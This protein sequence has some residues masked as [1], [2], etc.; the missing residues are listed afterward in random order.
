MSVALEDLMKRSAKQA[1][2]QRHDSFAIREPVSGFEHL[3]DIV[4]RPE[5]AV[6]NFAREVIEG[7][8][9]E[10]PKAAWEGFTG[11]RR[12]TFFDIA[13]DELGF[14]TEPILNVP[15]WKYVPNIIEGII[16]AGSSPA[17]IMGFGL[18]VFLD[19]LSWVGVGE[20]TKLGEFSRLL[21]GGLKAEEL[22]KGSKLARYYEDFVARTGRA[23]TPLA[24]TVADQARQGQR[25]L[26]QIS[27]PWGKPL[28]P[29]VVGQPAWVAA[30]QLARL[31]RQTPQL[32]GIARLFS[33]FGIPGDVL[34]RWA[35]ARAKQRY[36][37]ETIQLRLLELGQQLT[38]EDAKM[39]RRALE[40]ER[41]T[42]TVVREM[43]RHAPISES[44]LATATIVRQLM[45]QQ[46]L[47]PLQEAFV[48]QFKREIGIK[49]DEDLVEILDIGAETI[50]D[51][52][53]LPE[54]FVFPK[55]GEKTLKELLEQERFGGI[56]I[57]MP[58]GFNP[59]A[60]GRSG[61]KR[62]TVTRSPGKPLTTGEVN[63]LPLIQGQPWRA[64]F[65]D[66]ND[67]I[68]GHQTAEDLDILI[69]EL[70]APAMR[71]VDATG[72][73]AEMMAWTEETAR[74]M[75]E[76][77][78]HKNQVERLVDERAKYAA[79]LEEKIE[80]IVNGYM[81][82]PMYELTELIDEF[83]GWLT[84]EHGA[85][86]FGLVTRE[87]KTGRFVKAP[88]GEDYRDLFHRYWDT[89][90]RFEHWINTN[91][92]R[93]GIPKRRHV[94][95]RKQF[96]GQGRYNIDKIAQSMHE[97]GIIAGGF[98]QDLQSAME[99][100]MRSME[101]AMDTNFRAVAIKHLEEDPFEIDSAMLN[102]TANLLARMKEEIPVYGPARKVVEKSAGQ[103]LTH[104]SREVPIKSAEVQYSVAEEI[105]LHR[106]S[107]LPQRLKNVAL[108]L[109]GVFNDVWEMEA[110]R[111]L[112]HTRLPAYF[113]HIRY[114]DLGKISWLARIGKKSPVRDPHNVFAGQ[115]ALAGTIDEINQRMGREF[116]IEDLLTA[117]FIRAQA[118]A[119]MV[120][121]HDF[122]RQVV[123]EHGFSEVMDKNGDLI[124]G[125]VKDVQAAFD[126]TLEHPEWGVYFPKGER[127][128]YEA[129][130][131]PAQI[132]RRA[133]REAVAKAGAEGPAAESWKRARQYAAKK[134]G[135]TNWIDFERQIGETAE[136]IPS[137]VRLK[138]V[139]DEATTAMGLEHRPAS[140]LET[141]QWL[142]SHNPKD[143][144]LVQIKPHELKT[145]VALGKNPEAYLLPKEIADFMNRAGAFNNT[146]EGLVEVANFI[147]KVRGI[148]VPWTLFIFPGYHTRNAIGNVANAL[149]AGLNNPARYADA[150]WLQKH[151]MRPGEEALERLRARRW[152][153]KA[154][155]EE[156]SGEKFISE[157]HQH[158]VVDTGY[159]FTEWDEIGLK[160]IQNEVK[161]KGV[162]RWAAAVSP[163]PGSNEFLY[164]GYK[165]GGWIE[166]NAKIALY[167]DRRL[168]GDTAELAARAVRK[169]LF[170]YDEITP[171]DR[172]LK[173]YFFPFSVWFKKN[174][175]LQ[176]MELVQ[177]PRTF[178]NLR[179]AQQL[180]EAAHDDPDSEILPTWMRESFPV[181]I[182]KG[183]Q[184]KSRYEYFVLRNW[185]PAVELQ[186][187]FQPG[188]TTLEMLAPWFQLPLA[189]KLNYN[190]YFRRPIEQFGGQHGDFLR[191][192][193]E[194][195]NIEFMRSAR[196]LS[197]IDRLWGVSED[198]PR[199]AFQ[200]TALERVMQTLTGLRSF[201]VDMDRQRTIARGQKK[202]I[203]RELRM[204]INRARRRGDYESM[205]ML[206]EALRRE[207]AKEPSVILPLTLTGLP[208]VKR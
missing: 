151:G 101:T 55:T 42:E 23:P 129:V 100:M 32:A 29:L 77:A 117:T 82:G 167:I 80:G 150:F 51:G 160:R 35:I 74:L 4:S 58:E 158:G 59:E 97:G 118:S 46:D 6:A 43:I 64:T 19:P 121:F 70:V 206:R 40:T 171:L 165:V 141:L 202:R 115:R 21:K 41:L 103:P 18:G 109:E 12:I 37:I 79:S 157:L 196:L 137:D 2:K 16:R 8:W 11:K 78:S 108:E 95:K 180:L 65:F 197:E 5:Y 131:V 105:E 89:Y 198:S 120:H 106:F 10:A 93:L 53:A 182:G 170:D 189:N 57:S 147:R 25:A 184:G 193:W 124:K 81:R 39:V 87:K 45:H 201:E 47:S 110:A 161:N 17:G 203:V 162:K 69:S 139:V 153:S 143:P 56:D 9:D 34:D 178:S 183:P 175:S 15:D 31:F 113:P 194:R 92:E 98:E 155:G 181:R 84:K 149:Y 7:D 138:H 71:G 172:W 114:E 168:K 90:R 28:F 133:I 104:V 192:T 152:V 88:L 176:M 99:Q 62:M 72:S 122:V 111:G 144:Y 14:S 163:D 208:E 154:T 68:I 85:P 52:G 134:R 169:Y 22:V 49:A 20:L 67:I 174:L 66:E 140:Y 188:W 142:G 166:N 48:N 135:M 50:P 146:P 125:K 128:F 127:A 63:E 145:I 112:Q 185:L 26:I 126:Y 44:S 107:N 177:H 91:R 116:L 195:K 173:T 73:R 199:H 191:H 13:A 83:T 204:H 205:E 30:T 190:F 102:K 60:L 86:S 148:W 179:R 159:T 187:V 200:P 3:L 61:V 75:R 1:V 186:R 123:R 156:I 24:L 119:R 33:H 36:D 96:I 132:Q 38:E 76:R 207:Q 164:W 136:V 94:S 27:T 54:S 130:G